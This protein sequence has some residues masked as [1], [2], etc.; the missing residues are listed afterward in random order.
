MARH[1]RG[2]LGL[3]AASALAMGTPHAAGAQDVGGFFRNLFGPSPPPA[4]GLPADEVPCP[5]V[6][7]SDGGAAITAY[8]GGRVGDQKSLRHQISLANFARECRIQGDGS[9]LVRVGVQGRVLLGPAGSAGSFATPVHFTVKVGERLIATKVQ[10]VAVKVG[11]GETQGTF[12]A[13]QDGLVVPGRDAAEFEIE[14]GLGQGPGVR[15]KALP[16]RAKPPPP[17]DQS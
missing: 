2:W 8:G 11:A 9:V 4:V 3:I 14:V 16:R 17:P 6:D 5:Q 12:T 10:Q 13:V 1:G 7:V 15:A